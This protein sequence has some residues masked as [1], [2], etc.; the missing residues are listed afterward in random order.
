M[1]KNYIF[2]FLIMIF[3]I[4]TY[5][6]EFDC[7]T[8][9]G[10]SDAGALIAKDLASTGLTVGGVVAASMATGP[11]AVAGLV[12][13]G[14]GAVY[15]VGQAVA[16]VFIVAF[17]NNAMGKPKSTKIPLDKVDKGVIMD[18]G[19]GDKIRIK[20]SAKQYSSARIIFSQP[21]WKWWKGVV[22]FKKG[23]TNTWKELACIYDDKNISDGNWDKSTQ[24]DYYLVFS[25][26]KALGVHTNMYA[27]T[28]FDQFDTKKDYYITWM[29]D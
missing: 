25:K 28:N 16:D 5:G 15:A 27:I 20:A 13:A 21:K 6:Q 7:A 1:T 17:K 3:S 2:S 29:E 23:D 11:G 4:T 8:G 10:V 22:L 12:V 19:D 9:Q 14:A 26:A 18:L 24:K